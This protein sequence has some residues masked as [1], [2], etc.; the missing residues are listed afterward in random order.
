MDRSGKPSR[1]RVHYLAGNFQ[2]GVIYRQLNE[3]LQK[4]DA[5]AGTGGNYIFYLATIPGLF[6]QIVTHLGE[7]A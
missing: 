7:L 1:E 4:V 2:E 3:R 6:G 5:E